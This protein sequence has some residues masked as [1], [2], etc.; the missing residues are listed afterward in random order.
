MILQQD[1]GFT[2]LVVT[3]SSAYPSK[4]LHRCPKFLSQ[5]VLMLPDSS[6]WWSSLNELIHHSFLHFSN[7]DITLSGFWD[8]SGECEVECGTP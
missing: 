1:A 7:S 8:V 3:M 4:D 5:S 6:V 2:L